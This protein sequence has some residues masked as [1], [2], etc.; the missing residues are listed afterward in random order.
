MAAEHINVTPG[1]FDTLKLI[2]LT[3]LDAA[4][5]AVPLAAERV[6]ADT[7]WIT[8]EPAGGS[9][10]ALFLAADA[11]DH[12]HVPDTGM[13]LRASPGRNFDL[14]KIFF[15]QDVGSG[16]AVAVLYRSTGKVPTW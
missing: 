13:V 10:V 3:G 11:T 4:A 9:K 16:G 6:V 15:N 5:D 2:R 1:A 8:A 14:S 7:L 12:I